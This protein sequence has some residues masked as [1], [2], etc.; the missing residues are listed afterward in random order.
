[1][2]VR[3]NGFTSGAPDESGSWGR[4]IAEFVAFGALAFGAILLIAA[5]SLSFEGRQV[6][7]VYEGE[8]VAI[9]V[10]AGDAR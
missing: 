6:Q 10:I 1:M 4:R 2:A 3:G 9:R 8:A 5:S 7:P